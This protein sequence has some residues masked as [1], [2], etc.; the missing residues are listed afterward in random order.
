MAKAA[1]KK[2]AEKKTQSLAAVASGEAKLEPGATPD[3]A[4][5]IVPATT[6]ETPPTEK[7]KRGRPKGW[8]KSD[9]PAKPAKKASG[10]RAGRPAKTAPTTTP[11]LGDYDLALFAAQHGGFDAVISRL[12]QLRVE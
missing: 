4:G 9:Q 10:K 6:T 2:T 3:T 1:A 8:K 11:Q 12:N 5:K 7:K